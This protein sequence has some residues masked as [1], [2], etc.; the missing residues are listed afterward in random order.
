MAREE[1]F[2]ILPEHLETTDYKALASRTTGIPLDEISSVS[3]LKR[4]IDARKK[5]VKYIVK[6]A[7]YTHDDTPSLPKTYHYQDV[8]NAEPVHI[9]GFGSAGM[10]AALRCLELGLKP[11]VI[12]RGKAVKERRRDLA[13]LTREH[14]VNPDSNYCFGEGGAGT[15]SDGKLYTRSKKRGPVLKIL[16]QLVQHGAPEDILID[17]HPH[18][19]TN[20]LPGIVAHIRETVIEHGGEI[21]F[22]TRLKNIKRGSDRIEAIDVGNGWENVKHLILATGHSA[23]DVFKLL[24]ACDISIEMKPFALGLR[25]EHQQTL[26]DSSQYSC[27]VRPESLPPARY[28]L[29]HTDKAFSVFSFCMCPGGIIAPCATAPGE[30]VTNGWSPSK[31]NNPWANSGLVTNIGPEEIGSDN[32]MAGL[33][34]QI[35][36]EQ[37]A[38][39]MIDDAQQGQTAPAQRVQ[40]FLQ[41]KGS[42]SLPENSY[43]PG[44]QSADL[45]ALLGKTLAPRLKAAIKAF[46]GKIKGYASND[47]IL[48]GPESR[49]SSPIRIPRDKESLQHTQLAG[50]Y[51]CGEGAGYAGGIVSAAI[52]GQRCVEAIAVAAGKSVP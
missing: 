18:I 38:F 52:D 12:E 17:A 39:G 31:R 4:S 51:P 3:L 27:E 24:D 32:P 28:S 22:G 21:H 33:N 50:L 48:V 23:R 1:Q 11:I 26:I 47:G 2:E 13:Q 7:V 40:D 46:N 29:T 19:G 35:A 8:T 44:V 42:S 43:I 25:I 5:P 34:F 16:E 6:V 20:K 15:F 41:G 14:I 30:I 36:I 37:K 45:N 49:T 9:V 10:F